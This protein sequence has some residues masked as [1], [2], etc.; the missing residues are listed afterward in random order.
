M[1]RG[2][3]EDLPQQEGHVAREVVVDGSGREEDDP[4]RL[5]EGFKCADHGAGGLLAEAAA[6]DVVVGGD[7]HKDGAAVADAGGEGLLV[8]DTALEDLDPPAGFDAGEKP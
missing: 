4:G 2:A 1:G 3:E 5:A 7:D 6:G 8:V